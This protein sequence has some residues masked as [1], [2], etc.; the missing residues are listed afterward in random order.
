M[1]MAADGRGKR[2]QAQRRGH[3]A[4]YLAALFL[5]LK[6]YRILALRYRSKL[7][8]IDII[9]RKRDLIAIVE[10]KARSGEMPAVDAVGA[11]SQKRIHAA[12]DRWLSSR[13]DAARLSLRFDIVA[14]IPGRLPRHFKDAF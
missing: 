7:G 13:P 4:E 11:A 9:A 14:I 10:V 5:L 8:E 1:P 2:K 3:L 12:A 6:G